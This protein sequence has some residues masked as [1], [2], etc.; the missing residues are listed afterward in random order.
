MKK[1]NKDWKEEFE[2]RFL[3][4]KGN[5]LWVN[6][7]TF[8]IENVYNFIRQLLAQKEKEVI[9]EIEA[10]IRQYSAT[11]P[12]EIERHGGE[13]CQG[14]HAGIDLCIDAILKLKR[15]RRKE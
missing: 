7:D 14:M 10:I 9:E 3:I 5:G 15:L 6:P 4:R 11:L 1:Q 12:I 13:Y 2:E 8:K